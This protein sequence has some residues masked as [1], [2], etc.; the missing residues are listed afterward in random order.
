MENTNTNSVE[1]TLEELD[2]FEVG[3]VFAR[4]IIPNSPEGVYMSD[5]RVGDSLTWVAKKGFGYN[6]W[7]I[8][9]YW[10]PTTE[11]YVL[12]NGE[13]VVSE[14]NIRKL[15]PCTDEVFAKYRY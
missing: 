5:S 12:K 9:C 3:K 8:Y 1:L 11:A 4:G 10:S 13:K 6:D 2:S 7:C 15:V 14:L